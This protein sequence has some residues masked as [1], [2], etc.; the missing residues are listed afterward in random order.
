MSWTDLTWINSS[1]KCI[2][3]IKIYIWKTSTKNYHK[4]S[5]IKASK[6]ITCHTVLCLNVG[7]YQWHRNLQTSGRIFYKEKHSKVNTKQLQLIVAAYISSQQ[8]CCIVYSTECL[9]M[10]TSDDPHLTTDT[11]R[12]PSCIRI[13]RLA[14]EFMSAENRPICIR[15]AEM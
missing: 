7:S 14:T 5:I 8:F 12:A 2:I 4:I 3:L 11:N 10:W 6:Q 1:L 15:L 9:D 13:S